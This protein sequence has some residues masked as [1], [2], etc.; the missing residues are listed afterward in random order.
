[1]TCWL[2]FLQVSCAV[3][4]SCLVFA[5][6]SFPLGLSP[7]NVVIDSIAVAHSAMLF[8]KDSSILQEMGGKGKMVFVKKRVFSLCF[9]CLY[10]MDGVDV[11]RM[12]CLI[13]SV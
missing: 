12:V 10:R 13:S 4:V 9:L 1:M 11:V 8:Y 6:F 5:V 3:E 2:S 7:Y